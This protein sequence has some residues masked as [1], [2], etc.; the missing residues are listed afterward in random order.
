MKPLIIIIIATLACVLAI[1]V[2]VIFLR[3]EIR[4]LKAS[5]QDD[6]EL[7]E[8]YER[9]IDRMYAISCE[10]THEIIEVVSKEWRIP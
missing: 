3:A 7:I 2:W 1:G 8:S 10:G 4:Q 5:Q 6:A 9:I